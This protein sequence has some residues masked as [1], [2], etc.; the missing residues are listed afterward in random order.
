MK[1]CCYFGHS[2]YGYS[3]YFEI[4][5][6]T[7]KRLIEDEGI[8][9]FYGGG[10]G[11]F[12]SLCSHVIHEL[13]SV[14]PHIRNYLILSYIPVSNSNFYLDEKYDG[15]IYMLEEK[16]LPRFAISKTNERMVDVSEVVVSGVLH[17]WGGAYT[18][19]KYAKRKKKRI[20]SI[21]GV[22]L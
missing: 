1:I 5:K 15:S 2:N 9:E 22:E 8:T 21:T 6:T 12:D 4:I 16:V 10:R 20:I 7:F 17:T 19:C 11:L 13:K 3:D 18:A 14:Y